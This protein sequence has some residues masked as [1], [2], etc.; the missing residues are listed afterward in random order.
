[1]MGLGSVGGLVQKLCEGI[2]KHHR[3]LAHAKIE[4]LGLV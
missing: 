1:M 2:Q 3:V 4:G